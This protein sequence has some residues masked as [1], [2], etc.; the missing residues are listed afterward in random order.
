MSMIVLE[1]IIIIILTLVNGL[2]AMAEIAIVSGRKACLQ[3]LAESPGDFLSTV[4][5]AG[6]LRLSA[7]LPVRLSEY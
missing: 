1:I 6:G 7:F 5:V 2:L 4:Q 3:Q